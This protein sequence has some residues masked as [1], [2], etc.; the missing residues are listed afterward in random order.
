MRSRSSNRV[1]GTGLLTLDLI[2]GPDDEQ[3]ARWFAGGTCGN[4]LTIM[5]YLG[6]ESFPITRLNGDV[7]SQIVRNDLE[8]WGVNLEY[9]EL[10]PQTATPI[11]V[12]RIKRRKS[13][14]IV[15]GFSCNCPY[16]GSWLPSFKAIRNDTALEIASSWVA[17]TVFFLDRLS[18]GMLTLAK[19][20]AGAGSLVVFEPSAKADPK[21]MHEALQI[22]NIVKYSDQRFPE[23]LSAIDAS[24]SIKLEIQTLGDR[25]FRYRSRL[26]G[27]KSDWKCRRPLT[28]NSLADAAG[29]GD[30][31]TAALISQFSNGMDDLLSLRA[32]EL[33]EILDYA[34]TAAAWNC[35]FEGAR[36]GMYGTTLRQFRTQVSKLQ[37]GNAVAK[38]DK[39]K[40]FDL[41]GSF[42]VSPACPSCA[43]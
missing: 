29:A 12:Q 5:S 14:Q 26:S 30:W 7:A 17:P 6:W 32:R 35:L 19:E 16:C 39:S 31:F 38:H 27:R 3:P 36:T 15:H 33:D 21:H 8:A 9:A 34:R 2:I 37:V 10:S 28:V 13:G 23:S 18:R 11:I 1:F 4:V 40:W 24:S 20:A 22:A 43:P 25:G 42:E 41:V